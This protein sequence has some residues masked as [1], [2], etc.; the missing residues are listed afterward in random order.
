M[1]AFGDGAGNVLALDGKGGLQVLISNKGVMNFQ[2]GKE[3]MG[4]RPL[5]LPKIWPHL[6]KDLRVGDSIELQ[7]G[8]D[9]SGKII[10]E[11]LRIV[12]RGT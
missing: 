6:Y 12:K 7:W 5:L 8:T 9:K 4:E 11:N 3:V 10:V 1:P 2:A